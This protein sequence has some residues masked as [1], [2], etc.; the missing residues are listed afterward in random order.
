M[1]MDVRIKV[2]V[3]EVERWLTHARR[4]IPYALSKAINDTLFDARQ[5]LV[6][7]LPAYMTIRNRWTERG[8]RVAKASKATSTGAVGSMREYMRAQVEGGKKHGAVPLVGRGRPRPQLKSTTPP[9]RWPRAM[10]TRPQVFVG[11]AGHSR[12]VGVWQRLPR[13][14]GGPQLRLLYRLP[15][16]VAVKPR[17]PLAKIVRQVVQSRWAEHCRRAAARALETAR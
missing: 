4:Q 2:D 3:R 5:A 6:A 16:Q 1:T 7:E 10:A 14:A 17:Y 12:T 8:M 11:P 13:R 9:S 15:R